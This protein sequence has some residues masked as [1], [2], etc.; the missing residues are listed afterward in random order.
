MR[1]EVLQE[2]VIWEFLGSGGRV[3]QTTSLTSTENGREEKAKAGSE[4]MELRVPFSLEYRERQLF[5]AGRKNPH[6]KRGCQ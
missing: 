6:I 1:L 5:V 3:S 4:D 2:W